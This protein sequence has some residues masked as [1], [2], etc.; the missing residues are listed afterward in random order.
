MTLVSL[1]WGAVIVMC[2]ILAGMAIRLV[3]VGRRSDDFLDYE[4][5]MGYETPH[6]LAKAWSRKEKKK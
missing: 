3:W 1:A 5:D 6:S 4:Q 2:V